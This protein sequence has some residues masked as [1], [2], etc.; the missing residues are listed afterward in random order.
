MEYIGLSDNASTLFF[1]SDPTMLIGV[2]MISAA[3][4]EHIL[5]AKLPEN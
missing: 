2:K 4:L 5:K 3:R 1:N